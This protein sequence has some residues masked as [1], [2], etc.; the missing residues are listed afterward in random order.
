MYW[1]LGRT[2]ARALLTETIRIEEQGGMMVPDGSRRRTPGGVYL[3]L[4]YTQGVPKPGRVLN[5][6]PPGRKRWTRRSKRR[7]RAGQPEKSKGEGRVTREGER[8]V[9][10]VSDDPRG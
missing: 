8:R 10:A 6:Y 9:R 4:V 7:S 3:Y 5:R 2:Q 1:A